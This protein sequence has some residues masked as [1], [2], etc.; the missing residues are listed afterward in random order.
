MKIVAGEKQENCFDG[1]FVFKYFFDA[2][3]TAE[4]IKIMEAF[5][6]LRYY[7]SFP[8][9]MFHVQCADG[10]TIKGLQD[11]DECRVIFDRNGPDKAK[12][13]FEKRF[14]EIFV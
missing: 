2:K 5:G 12:E 3:W 4:T 7:D 13:L 11:T 9:P 10:T 1:D 8:K 14:G 6:R